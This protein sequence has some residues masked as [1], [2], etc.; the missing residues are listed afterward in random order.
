MCS[1]NASRKILPQAIWTNQYKCYSFSLIKHV[2]Y[3]R[4]CI[5]HVDF[6]YFFLGRNRRRYAIDENHMHSWD[7]LRTAHS[8]CYHSFILAHEKWF[9]ADRKKKKR[10]FRDIFAGVRVWK[11]SWIPQKKYH[12]IIISVFVCG[13]GF[14]SF[15]TV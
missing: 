11:I 12:K 7:Y 4:Y 10:E 2:Y 8:A 1:S 6:I 14:Y 3:C 15:A 5:S 13:I 9:S